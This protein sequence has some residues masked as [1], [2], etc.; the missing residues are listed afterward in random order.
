MNASLRRVGIIA[1]PKS[2][3]VAAV[4]N[5]LKEWFALRQ[6]EVFLDRETASIVGEPGAGVPKP[7]LPLRCDL[8]VV[9]GG[10]GTLLSVARVM[11]SRSVPILAVNFG[12][13]GFLTEITLE[14]TFATIENF[15]EGK[16]IK[17]TRMMIDVS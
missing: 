17:Q 15:L 12:S 16:A 5:Q 8:I 9:L 4:V 6:I 11:D 14:E 7:E 1:K 10:D 3:A 13:L 2:N